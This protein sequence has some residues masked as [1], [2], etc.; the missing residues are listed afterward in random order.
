MISSGLGQVF[1]S[2]PLARLELQKLKQQES[3]YTVI[4]DGGNGH[5]GDV[6]WVV[7]L[8]VDDN[9]GEDDGVDGDN[10]GGEW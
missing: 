1:S 3:N 10:D 7:E 9:S 5:F 6:V 8:V 2:N 4:T